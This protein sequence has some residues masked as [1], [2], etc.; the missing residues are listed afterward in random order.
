MREEPSPPVEAFRWFVMFGTLWTEV[1]AATK[2]DAIGI[3]QARHKERLPAGFTAR[4]VCP[5]DDERLAAW[6]GTADA[7]GMRKWQR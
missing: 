6:S 2:E 7:L 4:R 3:V 5:S 1:V